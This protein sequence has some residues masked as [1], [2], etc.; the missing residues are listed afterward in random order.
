[1]VSLD[2]AGKASRAAATAASTC[3]VVDTGQAA[4]TLPSAGF[5]TSVVFG[6]ATGRPAMVNA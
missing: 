1:M 4:T 2:H 5:R 3:S 6:V